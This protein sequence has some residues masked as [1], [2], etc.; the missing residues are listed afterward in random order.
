M[1][2]NLS[3][4]ILLSTITFYLHAENPLTAYVDPAPPGC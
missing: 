2:T 1:K 4:L 3:T